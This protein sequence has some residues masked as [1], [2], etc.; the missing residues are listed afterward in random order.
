M[1]TVIFDF[2]GTIADSFAVVV[3][4]FHELTHRTQLVR[5]EEIVRLRNMRLMDVAKAEHI[6]G[7][8]IP[9]LIVS[10]RRRMTKRLNE[11][12]VFGGMVDTIKQ[13]HADGYQLFIMSSNSTSNVKSFMQERELDQYF[14]KTYGGVGLLGKARA[15]KKILRQNHLLAADCIYVG[16][17][18]RD[19]EGSE[20]AGV[21]CIAVS[22]GFNAVELLRE[23]HPLAIASTPEKL[24]SVIEEKFPKP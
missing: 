7:W 19:I 6:S 16:D 20:A 14:T 9:L 1:K 8:R 12:Q 10:G 15:L 2:D 17:E 22:W 21:A 11:V 3:A 18:P 24:L 5:P 23:H 13:L 4:I